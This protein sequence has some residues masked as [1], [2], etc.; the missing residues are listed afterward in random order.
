[1][2]PPAF[3]ENAKQKF[4]GNIN[5][6][7]YMYKTRQRVFLYRN[8]NTVVAANEASRLK[9]ERNSNIPHRRDAAV[10]TMAGRSRPQKTINQ[11][12]DSLQPHKPD[13]YG[14]EPYMMM[15]LKTLKLGP[16]FAARMST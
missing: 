5:I 15:Q 16:K 11:I 13:A 8:A 6:Y 2:A 14:N 3:G 7:D 4:T 1:M 12:A 9:K 10:N